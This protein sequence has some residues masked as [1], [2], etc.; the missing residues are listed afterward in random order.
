MVATVSKRLHCRQL[1]KALQHYRVISRTNKRSGMDRQKKI[2]CST[3]QNMLANPG[4]WE[5]CRAPRHNS[6]TESIWGVTFLLLIL[7]STIVLLWVIPPQELSLILPLQ[8]LLFDYFEIVLP[9]GIA[10]PQSISLANPN[11]EE[12][13]STRVRMQACL[14][15]SILKQCSIQ[16]QLDYVKGKHFQVMRVTLET[17]ILS[18]DPWQCGIL[19]Q[20]RCAMLPRADA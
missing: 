5:G 1:L 7:A 17:S 11:I 12:G 20:S 8:Q 2:K 14:P 6:E 13:E 9:A 10:L 15:W 18:V 19:K 16:N 3:F 4:E